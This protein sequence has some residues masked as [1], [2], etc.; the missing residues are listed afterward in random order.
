[1]WSVI[2]ALLAPNNSLKP[3][4]TCSKSF[5]KSS[6]TFLPQNLVETGVKSYLESKYMRERQEAA[7]RFLQSDKNILFCCNFAVKPVNI[8]DFLN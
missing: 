7:S 5:S 2:L 3:S 1:M 8:L 4:H 6:H